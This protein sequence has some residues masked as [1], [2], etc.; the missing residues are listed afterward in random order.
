MAPEF[1]KRGV[2]MIALSCDDVVS[3]D[4]WIEVHNTQSMQFVHFFTVFI[5]FY[6]AHAQR[7]RM[8]YKL[9]NHV[10]DIEF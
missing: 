4:G 3:H 7:W 5:Y 1:A 6:M 2:K 10:N 9:T 8:P